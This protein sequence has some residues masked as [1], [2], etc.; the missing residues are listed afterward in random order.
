M[1]RTAYLK[2]IGSLA[3]MFGVG[4]AIAIG[5]GSGIAAADTG[6]THAGASSA[7]GPRAP[8][9]GTANSKRKAP[10]T[11]VGQA[12][13][14]AKPTPKAVAPRIKPAAAQ[15]TV[16]QQ[17]S[18]FIQTAIGTVFNNFLR[19][20]QGPPRLPPGSTVTLRSASL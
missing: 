7:A 8:A 17:L 10:K 19:I 16:V 20:T 13:I 3:V 18:G 12:N 9:H 11:T 1:Q 6:A 2:C 4:I 15:P 5:V 14:A